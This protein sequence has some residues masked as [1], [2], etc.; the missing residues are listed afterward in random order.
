M[1]GLIDEMSR[2]NN[3][4][5]RIDASIIQDAETKAQIRNTAYM[6]ED[7]SNTLKVVSLPNDDLV[8]TL[9]EIVSI[10]KKKRTAV[11]EAFRRNGIEPANENGKKKFYFKNEVYSLYASII[12]SKMD[13]WLTLGKQLDK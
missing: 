9:D 7:I 4:L 1:Y 2:I 3:R 5:D 12:S 6:V 10:V 11:Y 13:F 8:V